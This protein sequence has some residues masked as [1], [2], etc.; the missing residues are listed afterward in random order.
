MNNMKLIHTEIVQSHLQ[1][2]THNQVI[3]DT[4]P[5]INAQEDT[6]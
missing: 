5:K 4:P 3:N 1:T 2:R 6:T